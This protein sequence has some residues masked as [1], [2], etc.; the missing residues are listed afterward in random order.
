MA[1]VR[2]KKGGI[3]VELAC[4]PNTVEAFRDRIEQD[5]S[6]V[7]QSR[8][9]FINVSKGS[10]AKVEEVEKA[11]GTDDHD[12]IL[13]EI[14]DKGELQQGEKER[15][16]ALQKMRKEIASSLAAMSVNPTTLRPYAVTLIE[17]GEQRFH[18]FILFVLV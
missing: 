7:L 18:F 6:N 5:M 9:F 8:Q 4:Y 3:R 11:F 2:L 17:K 15:E 12:A 10:L 1:I 14:L 13:R 16:L